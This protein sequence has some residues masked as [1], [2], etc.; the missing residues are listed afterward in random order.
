MVATGT[1]PAIP[2]GIRG[3]RTITVFSRARARSS[4]LGYNVSHIWQVRM[5]ARLWLQLTAQESTEVRTTVPKG[6]SILAERRSAVLTPA[7]R[8]RKR[9]SVQ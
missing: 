9:I 5:A 7:S 6:V 2:H 8:S 3:A 4:L 1:A